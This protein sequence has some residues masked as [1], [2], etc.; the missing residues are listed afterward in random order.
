MSSTYIYIFSSVALI[1]AISLV[2]VFSLLLVEF[3]K[4]LPFLVSLAVGALF[5]SALLHLIPEALVTL[6]KLASPLVLLGIFVF[7]IIEHFLLLHHSHN[8]E[9]GPT[10]IKP[11]GWLNIIGDGMHN[12]LDGMIVAAAFLIDVNVGIATTVAVI[13]HEIPQ[14]LGDFAVLIHAGF[15]VKR[16]LILNLL[17]AL[18]AVLGAVV[19]IFGLSAVNGF[20]VSTLVPIA[21]GGF[22]YIA[23][24]DLIPQLHQYEKGAGAVMVQLVGILVGMALMFFI[25]EVG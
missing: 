13:L 10:S 16:A 20:A 4:F 19:V 23:G 9:H 11:V 8:H 25:P 18:A 15:S 17:S 6:G 2:G 7:F 22:L 1:S 21:A 5:G 12:F 3:K 24:S 14:E